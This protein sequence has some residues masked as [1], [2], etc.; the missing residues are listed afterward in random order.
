MTTT[1]L[2]RC[3]T[4]NDQDRLAKRDTLR[5]HRTDHTQRDVSLALSEP[6]TDSLD[7]DCSETRDM[8]P[9]TEGA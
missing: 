2:L 4:C 7:V 5:S 3:R 9:E 8:K 6:G 1:P